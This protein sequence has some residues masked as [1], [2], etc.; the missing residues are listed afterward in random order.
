MARRS[1]AAGTL[2]EQARVP[3]AVGCLVRAGGCTAR[4]LPCRA[5]HTA[6]S[7]TRSASCTPTAAS[8]SMRPTQVCTTRSPSAPPRPPRLQCLDLRCTWRCHASTSRRPASTATRRRWRRP[9]ERPDV[10]SGSSWEVRRLPKY[11]LA[12]N[13]RDLEGRCRIR[14]PAWQ[15]GRGARVGPLPV[16]YRVGE[17]SASRLVR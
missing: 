5:R 12:S 10:G 16:R 14:A 15:P 6:S 2:V 9:A 11:R 1:G 13:R 4:A 17:I 3:L 8:S 7:A